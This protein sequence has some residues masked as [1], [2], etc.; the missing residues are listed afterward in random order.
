MLHSFPFPIRKECPPG[1]CTC[2]RERLL[3][4]PQGD[5]RILRLTKEEEKKLI[6]RIEAVATYSELKHIGQRMYDQLGIVLEIL[7]GSNEVRSARGFHIRL[8]DHPG[9]CRK[10]CQTVPA[11]IRKCLDKHPDIAFSILNAH[12]LLGGD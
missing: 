11:A 5:L 10:T 6:A 8:L 3:E 9:L 2:G 12:D 4:H 7:P 1:A